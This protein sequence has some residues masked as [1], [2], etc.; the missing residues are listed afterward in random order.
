MKIGEKA[1]E[2]LVTGAG[3]GEEG[4]MEIG[5]LGGGSD[6][7]TDSVFLGGEVGA[8]GAVDAHVVGEGEGAIAQFGGTVDE[9]LRLAGAAEEGERGTGVEFGK[10]V[11]LG[12]AS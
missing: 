6:E 1:T 12:P 7:G 2:V 9:V 10:Q 11:L 5:E 8:S 3:F 4:E